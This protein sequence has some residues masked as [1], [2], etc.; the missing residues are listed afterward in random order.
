MGTQAATDPQEVEFLSKK[1]DEP[2][3]YYGIFTVTELSIRV[4]SFRQGRANQYY[5]HFCRWLGVGRF[6]VAETIGVVAGGVIGASID[7][8]IVRLAEE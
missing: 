3:K 4:G 6:R 8:H 7:L 1:Y 2:K 5:F